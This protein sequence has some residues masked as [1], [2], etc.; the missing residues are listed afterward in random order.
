MF[1][2][3][4][5]KKTRTFRI[6][7]T[8][9]GRNPRVA[10]RGRTSRAGAVGPRAVI[11]GSRAGA[12]GPRAVIRGSRAGAVGLRAV[13]GGS[14]PWAAGV[15]IVI[16]PKMDANSVSEA[17][18]GTDRRGK[19]VA[20]V[21]DE[22]RGQRT[23]EKGSYSKCAPYN[24]CFNRS[25]CFICLL[26]FKHYWTSFASTTPFATTQLHIHIHI[27]IHM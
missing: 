16:W 3:R 1:L 24:N 2:N 20:I 25:L 10:G 18:M 14:G 4:K 13:V 26:Y 8:A 15:K 7:Q 5:L 9:A 27:H 22:S 12:A 21:L 6:A 17:L 11:R 23:S 19:I